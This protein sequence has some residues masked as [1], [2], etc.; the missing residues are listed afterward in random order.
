MRRALDIFKS[1]LEVK[2]AALSYV[3][4]VS[5]VSYDAEKAARIANGIVDAY[6]VDQLDAKYQATLRA[7][8]WLQDRIRDLREQASAA[9]QA[10]VDYRREHNIVDTAGKPTGGQRMT[11]NE[12]RVAEL[13]SQ[14]IIVRAQ[15]AEARARLDR[16]QAVLSSD[17][18]GA[19]D[20]TVADI[21]KN[22]VVTKLR[23][24]YLDLSRKEMDWSV[25]Y[26]LN[27]LAVVNLRDQMKEE[28]AP[29]FWTSFGGSQRLTESD[30][31]IAK[32]RNDD[33]QKEYDQAVSQAEQN[34]QAQVV[35]SD[36]ESKSKT[37][38]ALYENFLQRY[39]EQFSSSHS[40]SQRLG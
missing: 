24:Q 16:I 13:N 4:E 34:N 14:L 10:V 19:V 11:T 8:N 36:L 2:R 28:L 21:L 12:Q 6:I 31:E 26:G 38:R 18:S 25:R 17:S 27:H 33:V 22:D 5:F 1:R 9:E 3:I 20:F 15:M 23:S 40:R 32:Q 30:L 29:L 35:L 37:Y 39:I 7:G